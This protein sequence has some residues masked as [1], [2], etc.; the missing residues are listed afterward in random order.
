MSKFRIKKK[1]KKFKAADLPV[2]LKHVNLDA[3][4]I[5][6]GSDRHMVAVPVGRAE[7]S[8]REFGAFTA[9]LHELADWLEKCASQ[10]SPWNQPASTGYR[11]SR[12]WSDAGSK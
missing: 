10:L 7:V 1:A 5:D 2:E 11:S 8:V 6:I 3:A 9:D 12:S 4:G